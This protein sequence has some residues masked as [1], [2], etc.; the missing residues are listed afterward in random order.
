MNNGRINLDGPD[1]K[2]KFDMFRQNSRGESY[3]S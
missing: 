1:I 3:I 2:K